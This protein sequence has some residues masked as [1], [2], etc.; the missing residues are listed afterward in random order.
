MGRR[1]TSSAVNYRDLEGPADDEFI[2]KFS[3][4]FVYLF[5]VCSCKDLRASCTKESSLN[6]F[7]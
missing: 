2:C 4:L 5:G 3:F 1:K 7:P 6:V